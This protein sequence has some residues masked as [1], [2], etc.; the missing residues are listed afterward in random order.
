MQALGAPAVIPAWKLAGGGG[1][2]RCGGEI[3]LFGGEGI[4]R[5]GRKPVEEEE[6]LG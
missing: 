6:E 2:F 5:L 4:A 3:G 1:A